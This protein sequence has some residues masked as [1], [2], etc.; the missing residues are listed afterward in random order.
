MFSFQFK[1]L[2]RPVLTAAL[3]L[4]MMFSTQGCTDDEV[5]TSLGA[6]AIVAGAV[7]IG[8]ADH[9]PSSCHGGYTRECLSHRDRWGGIHHSCRDIYDSCK[10]Y[11]EAKLDIPGLSDVSKLA[12]PAVDAGTARV[13]KKY[14][15]S[16]DAAERLTDALK[17]ARASN[18]QPIY[19]LGLTKADLERLG[20]MRMINDASIEALAAKLETT[21]EDAK[22]LVANLLKDSK[23][24]ASDSKSA[25]WQSCLQ[26]KKWKT[27]QNQF[28][29]KSYW[30][31]CSPET[32]ATIC[33]VAN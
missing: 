16:F 2:V 20:E 12:T 7:A 6:I 27:P 13:A 22:S 25:Y 1:T 11:Y 30:S 8:A 15:L 29:E 23:A 18:L 9:S 10:Y 24:Q 31:G 28:C 17:A 19:D 33:A 4:P 5:A 21:N 14:G 26:A 32:G 3:A